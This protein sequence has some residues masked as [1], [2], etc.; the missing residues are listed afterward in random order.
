MISLM[1]ESVFKH[2]IENQEL[3]CDHT[4]PIVISP[5]NIHIDCGNEQVITLYEEERIVV[6]LITGETGCPVGCMCVHTKMWI[7]L[8]ALCHCKY[9]LS[10]LWTSMW[11]HIIDSI[12]KSMEL[13]VCANG[14]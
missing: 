1:I 5:C 4:C 3:S 8:T 11:L 14:C 6:C 2:P 7:P 13:L 12:H 9:Y 10:C